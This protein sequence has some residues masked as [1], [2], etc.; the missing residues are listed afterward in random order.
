MVVVEEGA[1]VAVASGV[2]ELLICDEVYNTE[3]T[4]DVCGRSNGK[5]LKL[6]VVKTVKMVKNQ[7]IFFET[8]SNVRN[9]I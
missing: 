6:C 1:G 3:T 4:G 8:K 7:N 9:L 5:R 2:V